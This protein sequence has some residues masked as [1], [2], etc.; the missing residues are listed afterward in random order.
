MKRIV[1]ILLAIIL[2]LGLA[3]SAASAQSGRTDDTPFAER[4]PQAIEIWES[5]ERVEQTQ[6]SK[7]SV[8]LHEAAKAAYAIVEASDTTAPGTLSGTARRFSGA[9]STARR[10]AITPASVHACARAR[11]A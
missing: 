5:I 2:A 7:R 11:P 6:M 3:P 9:R 1:A 8:D 4:Y 10:A